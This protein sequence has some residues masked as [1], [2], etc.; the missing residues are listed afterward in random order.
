MSTSGRPL[1]G[2]LLVDGDRELVEILLTVTGVFE[3]LAPVAS[4]KEMPLRVE[5][6]DAA[7]ASVHLN[8][9]A[10]FDED[11]G[12][13]VVAYRW[14]EDA[15]LA[16][17][18][19]LGTTKAL[20]V[21]MNFGGHPVTLVVTDDQGA[22][23][24]KTVLI[25]V[26]DAKIDS[27]HVPADLFAL[28]Q[29]RSGAVVDIGTATAS[30]GCSGA[31]AISNDAP[32]GL[33]FPPGASTVAWTF[34]DHH[35]NV[36]RQEQKVFVVGSAYYP[37]PIASSYVLQP[38]ISEDSPEIVYVYGTQDQ[39]KR[40]RAD[41]HVLVRT[42]SGLVFAVDGTGRLVNPRQEHVARGTGRSFGGAP[43][44]ASVAFRAFAGPL[45]EEG[46]YELSYVLTVPDGSPEEPADVLARDDVAL[47]LRR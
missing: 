44:Q 38:A 13:G 1:V 39:G 32:P 26:F 31:V 12:S 35:G 9:A 15:G 20:D 18:R 40:I 22:I 8:A 24:S 34:D 19:L 11:P 27:H 17:Q 16:T 33:R 5:C 41:E 14:T 4:L 6:I 30:D 2:E 47:D 45:D 46:R 23:D 37:P 21:K 3:N 10:S 43:T 28:R 29:D 7:Q 42:P 25:D 36:A